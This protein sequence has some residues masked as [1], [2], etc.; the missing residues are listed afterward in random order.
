MHCKLGTNTRVT[1]LPK[2]SRPEGSKVVKDIMLYIFQSGKNCN[3]RDLTICSL[4]T[5][6]KKKHE[7]KKIN[8]RRKQVAQNE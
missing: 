4:N 5:K 1:E 6:I 8:G 2:D 7:D 3:F